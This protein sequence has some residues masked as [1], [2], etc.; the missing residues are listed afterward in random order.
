M[1]VTAVDKKKIGKELAKFRAKE[2]RSLRDV[3][4]ECEISHSSLSDF[5]KG[6]ILPS[7]CVLIKIVTALQVPIDKQ[8]K[9]FD[10]YA[11]VKGT[12]PP[13][14]AE[15]LKDNT[16]LILK[17]RDLIQKNTGER[18]ITEVCQATSEMEEKED[19]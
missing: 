19:E 13:D 5:E 7:E 4:S 8:H 10:L 11:R 2:K 6:V 3:A 12:A 1:S 15:S 14:I 16:E 18:N 17:V 9:L